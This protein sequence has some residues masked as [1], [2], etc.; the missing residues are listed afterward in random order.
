MQVFVGS[1]RHAGHRRARK[2][3]LSEE[4][5]AKLADYLDD[6]LSVSP[7]FV[8]AYRAGGIVELERF[9]DI[10]HGFA[11]N[12]GAESDRALELMK[13]FVARQLTASKA[14]V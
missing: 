10:P 13:A 14:T 4:C 9:P 8:A 7:R 11:R 1:Q 5:G 6:S 2:E 3:G 12:P